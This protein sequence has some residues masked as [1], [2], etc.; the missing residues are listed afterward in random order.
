MWVQITGYTEWGYVGV[1]NNEPKMECAPVAL[2]E[3]VEFGPEHVIDA[4]PPEN[5][6]ADT[7]QY[8]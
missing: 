1:L 3:R 4:L 5:W 6:N 7:Q 2:G 8:E